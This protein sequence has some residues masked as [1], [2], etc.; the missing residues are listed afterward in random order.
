MSLMNENGDIR[1]DLR[2]PDNDIGKE[3]RNKFDAS[4]DF[5]VSSSS[6]FSFWFVKNVRKGSDECIHDRVFS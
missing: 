5:Y 6:T 4:E 1:E 2:V 3:I